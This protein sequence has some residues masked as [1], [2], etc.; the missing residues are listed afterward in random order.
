MVV[1]KTSKLGKAA[2]LSPLPYDT[3]LTLLLLPQ[4]APPSLLRR[5]ASYDVGAVVLPA[6]ATRWCLTVPPRRR[7]ARGAGA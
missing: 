7:H 3:P 4:R 5:R 6:P 2:S 1:V